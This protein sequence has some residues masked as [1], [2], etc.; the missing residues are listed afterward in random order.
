M[1]L[2]DRQ[3]E[4]ARDRMRRSRA[5]A[6]AS[7]TYKPQSGS[8]SSPKTMFRDGE[9][10]AIDGEG[11]D[12]GPEESFT[13]DTRTYTCRDHHY[14][15]LAASS[16]E[17]I[18]A[19]D[20]ERLTTFQ[21][22]EFL[23]DVAQHNRPAILVCFAGGYDVNHILMH[24]LDKETLKSLQ[25][26]NRTW[27]YQGYGK[28]HYHVEYRPRKSLT[29]HRYQPGARKPD[30]KTT[31]WDVWG[32]FQGSFVSVIEKWLGKDHEDYQFIR[33]MKAERDSFTQEQLPEIRIYNQAELRCLVAVMN[34]V[35]AAI[36]GLGLTITRWDGAGAIAGAINKLHGIKEHKSECPPDVFHAARIAYSGGHIEAYSVG[37]TLQPIYHYDINSAYPYIIASLPSLAGGQ[38]MHGT[39]AV[40][41]QGFTLVRVR[42][43]F[44]QGNHF[45]PLF[46]RTQHKTILYPRTGEGWYWFPEYQAA[47]EYA[48]RFGANIFEVIEWR[49][50]Q[51]ATEQ[52]PFSF[53]PEYYTQRQEWI[54]QEH[55]EENAWKYGGEK[56]I[57]LGLNSLYG[58]MAQQVGG[59]EGKPPSYF[60]LEWAGYVT[61]GVRAM[62]MRAAMQQMPHIIAIATDGIFATAPLDLPTPEIK[63]L[64]A[65]EYKKHEG[66]TM[67]M[68]GVYWLHDAGEKIQNYSRGFDKSSMEN[69]NAVLAAW[70]KR[71]KVL[72]VEMHRLIGLGSALSSETFWKM[73]GR[74]V[75]ADRELRLDGGNSKRVALP[76]SARPA[77]GLCHTFPEWNESYDLARRAA[78]QCSLLDD[79]FALDLIS[80]P[81]TV[82]WMD[83]DADRAEYGS[84][85]EA[86][87]ENHDAQ[88]A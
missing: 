65:W 45:Y 47:A 28:P 75:S 17:E 81:Y 48:E 73:R 66:I 60:Q 36:A 57:K 46:F 1:A 86:V 26:G 62:L 4:L 16:G 70:K 43:D 29:I 15:L 87:M 85:V 19:P 14:T 3:R 9:F 58:K 30:V 6:R 56:I 31:L 78:D 25:A 22:L 76:A 67:V 69:P 41:P 63:Q 18:I 39:S 2:T 38:W 68:P 72:S 64:G 77:D 71:K 32:F 11:W 51:P 83:A 42:F 7:G 40:V 80:A 49:H 23:C 27:L 59:R 34:K 8:K 88:E 35:R 37:H 33:R 5:K 79:D 10:I 52:K 53:V 13:T 24:G 61:S 74:F 82:A 12:V 44:K 55:D 50:F 21:C 20:G 84:E 54:Q